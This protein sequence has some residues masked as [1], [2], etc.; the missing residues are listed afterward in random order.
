MVFEKI[1]SQKG[2]IKQGKE[3]C[4]EK[5]GERNR[6]LGDKSERKRIST[7]KERDEIVLEGGG[8]AFR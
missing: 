1:R 4:R 7:N 2:D 5:A 8:G 3:T 6:N